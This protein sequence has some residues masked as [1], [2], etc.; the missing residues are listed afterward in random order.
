M[1]WGKPLDDGGSDITNYIVEYCP[2]GKDKW[3]TAAK[4]GAF[5]NYYVVTDLE[6]ERL[7]YFGISAENE[8]G[9]SCRLETQGPIK[10]VKPIGN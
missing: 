7:Y 8:I 10:T 1:E 6:T 5:V 3:I 9:Q 4:V 2:E